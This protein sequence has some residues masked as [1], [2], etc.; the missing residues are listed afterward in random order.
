MGRHTYVTPTSYLE[1]IYT[2]NELLDAQRS[3]VQQLRS[4]Y[5]VGLD[6]LLAA[7]GEVNVMKQELIELQPK[8]VETG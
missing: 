4:R 2:Y 3:A 5:E 6:K 7:E 8:L 1:L